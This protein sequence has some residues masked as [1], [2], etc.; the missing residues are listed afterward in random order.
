MKAFLSLIFL[1]FLAGGAEAAVDKRGL[2]RAFGEWIDKD[3]WAEAKAAGVSKKIFDAAFK[4]VTLDWEMPE[5]HPP[6]APADKPRPEHQAEF[7]Q[8]D[9][10]E[11]GEEG[12]SEETIG[13]G[14][15]SKERILESGLA[16]SA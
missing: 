14:L 4:G 13:H 12:E 3:I 6:G 9:A 11:K 5:L 10:D 7:G 1:L 15:Y 2:E 8:P 16:V